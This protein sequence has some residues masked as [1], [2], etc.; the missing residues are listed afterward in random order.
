VLFLLWFFQY[1]RSAETKHK[2][3]LLPLRLFRNKIA[4][5][6]LGTVKLPQGKPS[7]WRG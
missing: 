1:T 5:L 7:P 2:D 3:V 6:R 4:N